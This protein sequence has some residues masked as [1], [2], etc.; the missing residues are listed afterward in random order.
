M[1]VGWLLKTSTHRSRNEIYA[2]KREEL[3]EEEE[4]E[5]RLLV[6][7]SL[8]PRRWIPSF[9]Q[10]HLTFP[11]KAILSSLGKRGLLPFGHIKGRLS[12]SLSSYHPVNRKIY[13]PNHSAAEDDW[14]KSIRKSKVELKRET[15]RYSHE[16]KTVVGVYSGN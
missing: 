2:I 14:Q 10:Y 8:N 5:A 6:G 3:V 4:A 15:I 12:I 7:G 9:R 16:A 13:R 1:S 11:Q